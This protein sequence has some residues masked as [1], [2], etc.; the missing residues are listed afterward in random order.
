[1]VGKNHHHQTGVLGFVLI[2]FQSL[3]TMERALRVRFQWLETL[4][5]LRILLFGLFTDSA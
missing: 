4:C 5:D 1:M 3:E 2:F